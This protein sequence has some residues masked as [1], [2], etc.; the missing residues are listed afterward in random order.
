MY[1]EIQKIPKRSLGIRL[2]SMGAPLPGYAAPMRQNDPSFMTRH[3]Q[4]LKTYEREAGMTNLYGPQELAT[5]ALYTSLQH[6]LCFV[7]S[8]RSSQQSEV[9]SKG[10]KCNIIFLSHHLTS[11]QSDCNL[12][13]S[14][15]TSPLTMESKHLP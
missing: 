1:K 14:D 7:I 8:C 9:L 6:Y 3:L 13:G 10:S 2:L 4:P 11:R 15:A 5:Q 12:A